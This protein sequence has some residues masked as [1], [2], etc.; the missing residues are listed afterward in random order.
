MTDYTVIN[1]SGDVLEDVNAADDDVAEGVVAGVTLDATELEALVALDG[2]A[3]AQDAASAAE[4]LALHQAL[5]AELELAD[6][7]ADVDVVVVDLSA[8]T[9][10]ADTLTGTEVLAAIDAGS[11]LLSDAL[12]D[13]SKRFAAKLLTT[14]REPGSRT[15]DTA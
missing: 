9:A 14:G 15:S 5:G 3:V 1:A 2:V 12:S 6:P 13:E 11:V 7:S 8:K 4:L 10:A